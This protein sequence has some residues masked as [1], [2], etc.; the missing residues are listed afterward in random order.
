MSRSKL[1]RYLRRGHM[2][3]EGWMPLGA[4]KIIVAISNAQRNLQVGGHVAEIGVHHGKLFVLLCLLA[5]EG[6][7]AV[8]VDLFNDQHKNIDNSGEGNREKLQSN[9]R[10]YANVTRVIFHQG[11]SLEINGNFLKGLADGVF[12]LISVDGGHT[13]EITS[14]DLATAED[15]LCEGGIII[16]DDCFNE[17][18]PGVS[19]GVRDFFQISRSIVPCAIGGNKVIFCHPSHVD[20]YIGAVRNVSTKTADQ[21]FLGHP[22]ICCNFEPIALTEKIGRNPVWIAIK[23]IPPFPLARRTYRRLVTV[24][25]VD[26]R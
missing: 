18:W 15:A 3:V 26:F 14:H 5:R 12:R 2:M 16:L 6:E 7:S 8:A 19:D 10:R 13:A 24:A 4:A 20:Y 25:R 9:L 11:D 17:M 1:D 23:D 22:V 21:H